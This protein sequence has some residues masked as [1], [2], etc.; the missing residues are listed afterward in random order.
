MSRGVIISYLGGLLSSTVQVG[1]MLVGGRSSWV[2]GEVLR[3]FVE[4]G[5]V[6]KSLEVNEEVGK[7]EFVSITGDAGVGHGE[8]NEKTFSTNL[9]W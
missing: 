3:R 5:G 9:T 8:E 7:V 4:L 6:G 1:G 2:M